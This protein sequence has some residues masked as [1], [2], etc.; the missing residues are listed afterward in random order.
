MH[1]RELEAVKGALQV[2]LPKPRR[3]ISHSVQVIA[4]HYL[5]GRDTELTALYIAGA[6]FGAVSMLNMVG[7]RA[8]TPMRERHAYDALLNVSVYFDVDEELTVGCETNTPIDL[9]GAYTVSVV[10]QVHWQITR[11]VRVQLSSGLA[12]DR[13][14]LHGLVGGRF[15]LE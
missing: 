1:D 15:I 5:H 9:H 4:E 14:R 11:R 13:G 10:P 7:A 2:T 8:R 3:D 6:R 12:V